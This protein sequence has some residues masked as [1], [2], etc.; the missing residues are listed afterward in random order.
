MLVG[1]III[2]MMMSMIN[3][4]WIP[5]EKYK[6]K[7]YCPFFWIFFCFSNLYIFNII[8][9]TCFSF[10]FRFPHCIASVCVYVCII[11]CCSWY[12]EGNNALLQAVVLKGGSKDQ[13][14]NA[15]LS[16]VPRREDDGAKYKCV[17]WNRAMNEGQR[18]ET[19]ATL[20]VNC[21]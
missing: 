15:T 19:T 20:N 9:S 18:L 2:M 10:H 5:P 12:R 8:F 4:T 14:T 3:C 1:L 11:C 6:K 21:K 13:P 7:I 16:I 17:V